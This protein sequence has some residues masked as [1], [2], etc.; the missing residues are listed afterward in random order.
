MNN[1]KTEEKTLQNTAKE[2]KDF[3]EKYAGN[4]KTVS[5]KI[6]EYNK[7]HLAIIDLY[8]KENC[9]TLLE[10][11]KER[12]A[13]LDEIRKKIA[14][15]EQKKRAYRLAFDAAINSYAAL[16]ADNLE[17]VFTSG[18]GAVP[19]HYKK[20]KETVRN[21]LAEYETDRIR[22]YCF[23]CPYHLN[24]EVSIGNDKASEYVASIDNNYVS[25]NPDHV[26]RKI[27]EVSEIQDKV[28]QYIKLEDLMF[29][30]AEEFEKRAKEIRDSFPYL[31]S[32]SVRK[33]HIIWGRHFLSN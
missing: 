1:F 26:E 8:R 30:Q 7:E 18:L 13:Q 22:V 20:F 23:P 21:I 31:Q 11:V 6:D 14:F 33:P 4:I 10:T 5:K 24:I 19:V 29:K 17:A 3:I 2:L 25:V 32:Q 15:L 27:Y 9:K 16:I 28:K 12:E